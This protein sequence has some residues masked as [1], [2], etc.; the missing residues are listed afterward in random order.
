MIDFG[1]WIMEE[2]VI[3]GESAIDALDSERFDPSNIN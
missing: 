2:K 1:E 3:A